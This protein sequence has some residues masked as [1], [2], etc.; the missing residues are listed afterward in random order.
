MKRL[1]LSKLFLPFICLCFLASCEKTEYP[2]ESYEIN[3]PVDGIYI[4]EYQEQTGFPDPEVNVEV[5][6]SGRT[7]LEYGSEYESQ[8]LPEKITYLF[9]YKNGDFYYIEN[10]TNEYAGQKSEPLCFI[11][12]DGN[13]EDIR[14]LMGNDYRMQA[15]INAYSNM[16]EYWQEELNSISD[17]LR[18]NVTEQEIKDIFNKCGY[19]STYILEIYNYKKGENYHDQT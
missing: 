12:Y 6:K 5:K 13:N 17:L 18:E 19:D 11:A 4:V 16:S 2:A 14:N 15:N 7:I 1:F 8:N 3:N 9:E 10:R